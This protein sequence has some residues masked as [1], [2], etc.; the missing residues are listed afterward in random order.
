MTKG[1]DGFFY[2]SGLELSCPKQTEL[3]S[4]FVSM[5]SSSNPI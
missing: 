2:Q 4:V 1:I 3:D 5:P